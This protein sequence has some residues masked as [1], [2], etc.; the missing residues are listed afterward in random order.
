[1]GPEGTWLLLL[2]LGKRPNVSFTI[3]AGKGCPCAVPS[4]QKY[5]LQNHNFVSHTGQMCGD[6]GL[7]SQALRLVMLLVYGLPYGAAV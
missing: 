1:M 5:L 4:L 3:Q 7:I 6:I 2:Q